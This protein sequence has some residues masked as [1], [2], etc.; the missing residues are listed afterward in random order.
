MGR[1]SVYKEIMREYEIAQNEACNLSERRRATLY[2]KLPRIQAIDR[3]MAAIGLS[4]A[5]MALSGNAG[6]AAAR[7]SYAALTREKAGLFAAEG[8]PEDYLTDVYRCAICR[9]TGFENLQDISPVRCICFKQ[10]LIDKLY[11][12]SN[13]NDVLARENFGTFKLT[14]FSQTLLEEEG[15]SPRDNIKAVKKIA[16][17]F[18]KPFKPGAENLFF[19]GATGLGK[20]FLCHCIAKAVLDEGYLVLYVTAPHLLKL[21]QSHQFNRSDSDE[22]MEQLNAVQEAELLILDD[23]GAEFSTIITDSALFEV[24]NQRLLDKRS[25]VISSNLS[26]LELKEQYTERIVSRFIGNYKM[27]KFFGEDIREKKRYQQTGD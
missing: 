8:I 9:D 24:I 11:A 2:K 6:I 18:T 25:T 3:E 14:H 7:A 19:Y 15:L 1:L 13:L 5:K 21:V 4:L 27:F 17:R 23:L 20:T 22:A 12:L 26:I 10:R 16:E